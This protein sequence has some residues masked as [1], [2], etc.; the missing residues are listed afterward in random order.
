[1]TRSGRHLALYQRYRCK[2]CER[3]F[4]DKTGTIFQDSRLP[5]KVW[6]LT[7]LLQRGMTISQV[8]GALGM[9][10]YTTYRMV[11]KLRRS[12]YPDII[13]INLKT[14]AARE[15]RAASSEEAGLVLRH[16]LRDMKMAAPG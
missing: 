9:Y 13:V 3:I 4:N 2:S 10:Y 15:T 14:I 11:A 6:F 16:V 1:V 8:S 12:A 7:A 5:L